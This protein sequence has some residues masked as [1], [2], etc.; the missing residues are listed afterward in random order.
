MKKLSA[1]VA[2]IAALALP[3]SASAHRAWIAPTAT[4]L[5][6]DDAWV[7]FDAGMSNGVFI[8]DHANVLLFL[9]Q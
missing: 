9:R 3:F 8:A 4:V 1:A 2:F 5:S 7:G 6:G